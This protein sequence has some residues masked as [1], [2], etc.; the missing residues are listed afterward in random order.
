MIKI[1]KLIGFGGLALA[2]ALCMLFTHTISQNLTSQQAAE[3]WSGGGVR[4]AQIS[5]FFTS[6]ATIDESQVNSYRSAM[7]KSLEEASITSDNKKGRLWIDT[8]TAKTET[9]VTLGKRSQKV[10]VIGVGDD[11]FLFHPQNILSGYY[12]QKDEPTKDRVLLAEEVAWQIF[13][14]SDIE[15]MDITVGGKNCKVAGVY[16]PDEG[17]IE[18]YAMGSQPTIYV[19]FELLKQLDEEAGIST[20]EILLPNPVR[21]FAKNMV[22]KNI[23]GV[24]LSTNQGSEVDL[25]ELPVEI[26]EN[27]NRFSYIRLLEIVKDVGFRSMDRGDMEYPYWENIARAKEDYAALYMIL[28]VLFFIFPVAAIVRYGIRRFKSRKWTFERI[29][30]I[31]SEKAEIRKKKKWE[32]KK[33]EEE[34]SGN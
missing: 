10:N 22:L 8:Y 6:N 21:Q 2:G 18:D 1:K 25:E 32:E 29:K 11:F 33:S 31:V 20:Y 34:K 7:Q 3:R 16:R 13:G 27:T 23:A 5:A 30:N 17:R 14:S 28:M 9:Q 4:Y 24:D 12:F 19:P 26:V 15:G